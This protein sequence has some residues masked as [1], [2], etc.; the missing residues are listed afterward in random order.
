[1]NTARGV[2]QS[3]HERE[4][5]SLEEAR[6]GLKRT[7]SVEKTKVEIVEKEKGELEKQVTGLIDHTGPIQ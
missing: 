6:V 5:R 4:T 3:S 2:L 7:L 1:M